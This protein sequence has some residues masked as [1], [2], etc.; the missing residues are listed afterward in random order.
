[1]RF[2]ALDQTDHGAQ[3]AS[4]IM[5][6]GSSLGLKRPGRGVDHPPASGAEDQ[7][8]VEIYLYSLS[9]PSCPVLG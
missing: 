9:G 8:T 4:Y 5:R 7:E 6:T 2:S 3:P 1:V